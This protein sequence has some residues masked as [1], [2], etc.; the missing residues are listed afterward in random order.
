MPFTP[1]PRPAGSVSDVEVGEPMPVPRPRAQAT[2]TVA[3]TRPADA[4]RAPRDVPPPPRREEGMPGPDPNYSEAR[5]A[6]LRRVDALLQETQAAYNEGRP[7]HVA[8]TALDIAREMDAFGIRHI[9][10]LARNVERAGTAEDMEALGDI[11]PE[12][13][14]AMERLYILDRR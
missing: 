8:M 13:Y 12:L 11:L 6:M 10:R 1:T 4:Q 7:Q 3:R 9:A 14:N 2:P 5:A